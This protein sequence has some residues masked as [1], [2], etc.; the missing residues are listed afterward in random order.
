MAD[1]LFAKIIRN[2]VV[3][4][5]IVLIIAMCIYII[6]LLYLLVTGFLVAIA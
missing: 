3:G 6:W 2:V 1:T 4:G 5:Q